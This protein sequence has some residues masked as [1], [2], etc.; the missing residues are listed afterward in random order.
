MYTDLARRLDPV[1]HRHGDVHQDDVRI[2][3][4]HEPHGLLAVSRAPDDGDARIAPENGL[5]RLGEE[6]VIVR[7]EHAYR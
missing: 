7:Y 1:H 2:E 5:E 4:L 6:T 3:L